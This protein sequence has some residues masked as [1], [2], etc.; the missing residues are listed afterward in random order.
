VVDYLDNK[1]PQFCGQTREEME[2][3]LRWWEDTMTRTFGATFRSKI[4]H[5][6]H[7]GNGNVRWITAV[8]HLPSGDVVVFGADCTE[9]LGFPNRQAWKLAEL[10]SKAE[11]GHKRLKVY[12]ARCAFLVQVPEVVGFIAA[13]QRPE[14]AQNAF[15]KDVLRKLDQYGSLSDRQVSAVRSSLQRDLDMAARRAVEAAEV[16][17]DAPEGRQDVTGQVLTVKTQETRFGYHDRVTLKMLVKLTN[18]AK[19]W[20]TCPDGQGIDRGDTVTVRATFTR[21]QDDKHFAFGKRP[22]ILNIIKAVTP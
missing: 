5:C 9:R 17:G 18:N 11:A 13:M 22:H 2:Q 12:N 4:F 14:H 3:E 7:C 19:V 10:K 20:L 1:R 16:K 8:K 15:V 6:C 21:S